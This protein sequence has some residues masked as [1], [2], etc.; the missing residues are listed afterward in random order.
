MAP[1]PDDE[2][3]GCGG[4]LCCH[5]ERADQVS[6]V[7]LT[8]GELGLKEMPPERA[9]DLREEEARQAA[10]ILGVA[11]LFFL[12]LPDW[13]SG[14]D[15]RIAGERLAPVLCR[16]LPDLIYLPHPRDGHPDHQAAIHIL[17]AG[18]KM[19]RIGEPTLRAYEIWTPM[20][21]FDVVEDITSTMPRKLCA[22]RAHRS[23]LN[24]FDYVRAI[25]GLNQYRGA[26]C[27]KSRYAEVFQTLRP[28]A[29]L[30]QADLVEC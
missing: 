7:F 5:T 16:C 3:L 18:L 2:A 25:C 4:T 1:H 10:R 20:M 28:S 26:L 6:I 15:P 21:E 14:D 17:T 24:D 30:T 11:S 9:R 19:A 27:A 8:S 12:R 23:Q 29:G 22:L 13:C